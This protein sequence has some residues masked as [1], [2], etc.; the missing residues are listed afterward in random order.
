MRRR[1]RATLWALVATLLAAGAARAAP[2]VISTRPAVEGAGGEIGFFVGGVD[3][4]GRSLKPS[5]VEVLADGAPMGAPSSQQPLSDYAAVA[6]ET[7]ATWRPPLAVGVVYLWTEGV[8]S[9]LLDAI[10][11]FF[12]R[13]P[14][15]TTVYP[16]IYGRM[17]QGRARL[18]AGE[19][20]RLDEIPYLDGHKPNAADAI[21]LDASDLSAD[22]APIKILLVVTDGRDYADPKGEG[23]GDFLRLGAEI[24]KAGVTPLVVAFPA[25]EADAAAAAANLRDLH[26]AAGG[27]LRTLEQADDLDN[28]LE[29][30]GQGVAD[31]LHVQVLP[32]WTW[33]AFG[34]THRLSARLVTSEGPRL[35]AELGAVSIPA[36]ALLWIVLLAVVLGAGIGLA[37][38]FLRR[39]GAAEHDGPVGTEELLTAVHDLIRR[40]AS[41][42]RAVEELTRN[43]PD[44]VRGLGD[45]DPD[46]LADPRYPYFRTR[47]GRLRLQEIRDMLAKKSSGRASFGNTLAGSLASAVEDR[48]PPDQAAAA[49]AARVAV[50]EWTRFAGMSLDE[51]TNGLREAAAAFPVLRTPRARGIAVSI[52]DQLR[53]LGATEAIH[54][55]WLVRSGGPGRRGETLRL[56]DGRNVIGTAP[57]CSVR[58]D[59]DP[60]V[61]PEH[62]E[63]SRE[64]DTFVIS[65]LA[66][67]T[68]VEGG[69]VDERRVL[70]DGD[71]IEVGLSFL[72]FKSASAGSLVAASDE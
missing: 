9:S 46:L 34:G 23:P 22:P 12:Q 6:S 35:A 42:E 43:Y 25:P 19:I 63:I 15:R 10:H 13:I 30:L 7:N 32:P 49:L 28:T 52:Q 51:L 67:S 57:G 4:T 62:A 55:G 8:P 50:E 54:V 53:F 29:S 39:R 70:S 41:P 18:T 56:T 58:V 71:T 27:F 61:A 65:P 16:T 68:R 66:G 5:A 47:P 60:G 1:P 64:G 31:L 40:G 33:R 38:M 69:P 44:A 11:G 17:R 72:V 26:E 45:V 14:S 59:G 48:T 36:G 3:D 24:R 2:T 37:I 20:G 21:R